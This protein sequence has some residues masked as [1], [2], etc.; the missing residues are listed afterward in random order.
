[1]GQSE[2]QRSSHH[3]THLHS[4]PTIRCRNRSTKVQSLYSK[5]DSIGNPYYYCMSTQSYQLSKSYHLVCWRHA[6]EDQSR[7]LWPSLQELSQ[8]CKA[9]A[10]LIFKSHL[11]HVQTV[12]SSGDI[13]TLSLRDPGDHRQPKLRQPASCAHFQTLAT[14]AKTLTRNHVA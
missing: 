4:L 9:K 11:I 5:L 13:F 7:S 12:S 1:M 8:K 2:V 14:Q 6:Q 3:R 10:N